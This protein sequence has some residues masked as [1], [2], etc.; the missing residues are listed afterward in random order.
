MKFT[1]FL[2]EIAK[3]TIGGTAIEYGL[4]AALIVVASIGAFESVANENTGLWGQVRAKSA[5]AIE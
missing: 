2:R 3:D 1:L 5:E 4:I